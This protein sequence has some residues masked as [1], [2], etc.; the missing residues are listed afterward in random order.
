LLPTDNDGS[1]LNDS[2]GK[3]DLW[4]LLYRKNEF[5]DSMVR[6]NTSANIDAFL[7]DQAI[8]DTDIVIWYGIHINH[9]RPAGQIM[10]HP[11]ISGQFVAGP[12]LIP[13]RW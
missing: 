6:T 1:A 2:Y 4:A 10:G 11:F 13:V 5:D 8:M 7:N 12:E 3:G 9:N